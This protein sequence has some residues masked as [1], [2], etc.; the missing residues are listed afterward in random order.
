MGDWLG[1]YL[2]QLV[3]VAKLVLWIPVD[4]V[5]DPQAQELGSTHHCYPPHQELHRFLHELDVMELPL[6]PDQPKHSQYSELI[7][8]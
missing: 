6:S 7:G 5:S 3:A 4:P 1:P 2:S 8:L